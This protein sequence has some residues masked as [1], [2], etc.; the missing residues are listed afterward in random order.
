[1]GY[2]LANGNGYGGNGI[3]GMFTA[4]G[5]VPAIGGMILNMLNGNA[6]DG[7]S[8]NRRG[9]RSSRSRTQGNSN[10]RPKAWE[11]WDQ[12]QQ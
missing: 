10:S 11:S 3:A 7:S 8:S 12:H 4:G 9:T 5:I 2:V 6:N 1:M